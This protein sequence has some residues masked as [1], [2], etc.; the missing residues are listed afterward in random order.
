MP[1]ITERDWTKPVL[2]EKTG[3]Y[4][5]TNKFAT[6]VKPEYHWW[7]RMMQAP[8]E[9]VGSIKDP[10]SKIY[11]WKRTKYTIIADASSNLTVFIKAGTYAVTGDPGAAAKQGAEDLKQNYSGQWKGVDETMVFAPNHQVAP[12]TE[13]LKCNVCHSAQGILD[14]KALG[15]SEDRIKSLTTNR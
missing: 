10:D 2:N 6:D 14:F 1:T 3:L 13:A 12:K 15:Y 5:P 8:P 4:G 11:P 7:N 9:P